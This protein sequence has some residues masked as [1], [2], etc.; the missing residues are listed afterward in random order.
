MGYP[1]VMKASAGGGGRGMFVARSAEEIAASFDKAAAESLQAFGDATLF[2]ERFVENARHVEVQVVG[3]GE[4]K[5][6]HF[7]E[8]D[9]SI[10]RRYQK[11][12]EEAPCIAMTD[13]LR[14]A[15]H[16]AAVDL[17]ASL[18]YRNAGTVEFLYD[19]DRDAFYF[20]EV[21][22]RIQVEH[23]VSE[24]VTGVDLVQQ[25]FKVAGGEGLAF[26]QSQIKI[27]RHA[28]ECRINAED[29]A[30]N[31]R[32]SP[33]CI[34]DWQA[35]EGA[36]I[37][38]DSH[39]HADYVVPPF[40]DSMIGKLIVTANDRP[41]VIDRLGEA[42]RQFHIAGLTTNREYAG[43]DR[44]A[45]EFS[46]QPDQYALAGKSIPAGVRLIIREPRWSTSQWHTS[47]SSTRRC[48]MVSRAC[49]VCGC[50]RVWRCRRV[51]S[52]IR[53]AFGSST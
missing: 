39:C 47:N 50:K 14:Q 41:A 40:Y 12:I 7:G 2:M 44:G 16:Q 17:L 9:C 11:V 36:G 32:P 35:P 34:S 30:R 19:V 29:P 45:F 24:Q 46:R 49:G 51:R 31:F 13:T 18:N 20:M 43:R 21:N 38:L 25:Q 53:P 23:P 3:D 8:R 27:S 42:L 5:V 33:G 26:E 6:I 4:G 48:A 15:L 1:V 10:Q 52:S 28:I 22:T 37:R